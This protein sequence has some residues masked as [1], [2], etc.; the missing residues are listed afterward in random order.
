MLVQTK[1]KVC[2]GVR[3][4][5]KGPVIV[6]SILRRLVGLET[7]VEAVKFIWGATPN[8]ER[9]RGSNP[10]P[11]AVLVRGGNSGGPNPC[12]AVVH[13]QVVKAPN[14]CPFASPEGSGGGSREGQPLSICK[15]GLGR[16]PALVHLEVGPNPCPFGGRF[17]VVKGCRAP[18]SC[19]F[20][21]CEGLGG[22]TLVHL[23]VVKGWGGPHPLSIVHFKG[24]RQ[25]MKGW[26]ARNPCPFA[27]R[28]GLGGGGLNPCP[29]ANREA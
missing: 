13:L 15:S 9:L 6:L 18:N 26:G 5:P 23:Q 20:A 27:R 25:V 19:P 29:F 1:F 8:R 11:T 17:Q 28:E 2:V 21:S 4:G 22:A 24:R 7:Y 12:P 10:C 3:S 14:P 16:P